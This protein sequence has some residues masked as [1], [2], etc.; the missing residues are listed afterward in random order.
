MHYTNPMSGWP[1]RNKF[2]NQNESVKWTSLPCKPVGV[3]L[4]L[5]EDMDVMSLE[6]YPMFVGIF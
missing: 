5:L 1:R 3:L 2:W 4:T 6:Y